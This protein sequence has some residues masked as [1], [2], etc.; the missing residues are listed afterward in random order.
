MH[1]LI[2]DPKPWVA[3]LPEGLPDLTALPRLAPNDHPGFVVAAL[4]YWQL[5]IDSHHV[6][7]QLRQELRLRDHFLEQATLQHLFGGLA[8]SALQLVEEYVRQPRWQDRVSGREAYSLHLLDDSGMRSAPLAGFFVISQR[9]AGVDYALGHV[10]ERQAATG[11]A[12][13]YNCGEDGYLKRFDHLQAALDSLARGLVRDRRQRQLV[14]A[15]QAPLDQMQL[16]KALVDGRVTLVAVPLRENLFSAVV[17]HQ[18]AAWKACEESAQASQ[19]NALIGLDVSCNRWAQRLRQYRTY[20]DALRGS[21]PSAVREP[22]PALDALVARQW[23][24]G[25]VVDDYFGPLPSFQ[26]YARGRVSAELAKLGLVA[27]VSSVGLMVHG[28]VFSDNTLLIELAPSLEPDRGHSQESSEYVSMLEYLALRVDR[29]GDGHR[30]LEWVGLSDEQQAV[31]SFRQLDELAARLKLEEGYQAMLSARLVRPAE[32][33]RQGR[34]D[35]AKGAALDLIASQLRLAAQVHFKAGLLDASGL[36]CVMHV[37]DYPSAASRPLRQGRTVKVQGWVFDG[38]SARDVFFF[39]ESGE[40]SVLL[41][42]PGYPGDRAFTRHSSFGAARAALERD[43]QELALM[44]SQ[45]SPVVRYWVGRFGGHQ[46]NAALRLLQALA[47]GKAGAELKAPEITGPWPQFC[48]DYRTRFLL[49]EA[50]SQSVSHGELAREQGL[51]IAALVFRVISVVVPGRLMT[52]LDLAELAYLS[53]SGYAAYAA[54]QREEAADYL[55]EALSSVSGL[56][57]ANLSLPR[58]KRL[59]V[60]PSRL[61][62]AAATPQLTLSAIH[63]SAAQAERFTFSQGPRR[64]LYVVRGGVVCAA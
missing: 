34:F 19:W 59:R 54:G 32:A 63:A 36:A 31:F 20:R 15:R 48:F 52:A 10:T 22:D 47:K 23:A 30:R 3:N 1:A 28:R 12:L 50:D 4:A 41:Y 6:T 58:A 51:A 17:A 25:K 39:S 21:W 7:R 8:H 9:P 11:Q 16:L 56:A 33:A 2:T 38:N 18:V 45:W 44:P 43:L 26:D 24:L 29:Q 55:L 27:D 13:L 42:T 49:A 46:Q 61:Q 64:G 40:S 57:N 14:L 35:T 62:Q 37:L 60:G 5:P 53:F